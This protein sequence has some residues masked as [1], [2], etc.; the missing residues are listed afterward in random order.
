MRQNLRY[1]ST[2][3]LSFLTCC[4]TS[5]SAQNTTPATTGD[6]IC[7]LSTL[8]LST[9]TFFNDNGKTA[10]RAN[11]NT[12][13]GSLVIKGTTYESGV[14][15]HADS[16]FVVKVNGATKF[17]AILGIDDGADLKTD[18]GIVDYTLTTYDANKQ[19][20]VKASGTITRSGD[21]ADTVDVDLS[22]SVYLIIN[23]DKG[24]KA[25]A[26]HVDL[27]DAYFTFADTKPELIAESKMGWTTLKLSTYPKLAKVSKTFPFLLSI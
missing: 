22:G 1:L 11:Q 16:K 8:D 2:L 19:S 15:T 14:G 5:L 6:N 17:H 10:V 4:F 3:V 27:G 20:T 18:H 25:W 24:A 21:K 13:G 26:D 12:L 7:Q 9:V 23:F